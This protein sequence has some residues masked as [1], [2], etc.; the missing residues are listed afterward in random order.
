MNVNFFKIMIIKFKVYLFC[1]L[2]ISSFATIFRSAYKERWRELTLRN[3]D[4]LYDARC[5]IQPL[6]EK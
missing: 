5:Y 2:N 6:K 3:L 1:R 4:N